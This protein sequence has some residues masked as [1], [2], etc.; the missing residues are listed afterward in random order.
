MNIAEV[1]II[2]DAFSVCMFILKVRAFTLLLIF[3]FILFACHLYRVEMC[4]N[5]TALVFVPPDSSPSPLPLIEVTQ[6][7]KPLCSYWLAT[8]RRYRIGWRNG[9]GPKAE[10]CLRPLPFFCCTTVSVQKSSAILKGHWLEDQR[11]PSPPYCR[12][13][14]PLCAV[15]H[16]SMECGSAVRDWRRWRGGRYGVDT[17]GRREGRRGTCRVTSSDTSKPCS[18]ALF[19]CSVL[20]HLKKLKKCSVFE[21]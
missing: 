15:T 5:V 13:L 9:G 12:D 14:S 8:A 7:C 3:Y 21:K 11:P 2:I 10:P 4:S 20:D 16:S 6:E 1:I 17:R 18:C 19:W